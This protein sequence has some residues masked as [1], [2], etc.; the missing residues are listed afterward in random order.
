VELLV[1]IGIISLLIGLLLPAL[2]VAQDAARRTQCLSNLRQLATAAHLYAANHHDYY[3][4]AYYSASDGTTAFGYNWDFTTT[5][6]LTTGARSIIPG[7]LWSGQT[8]LRIQQCPSYD[9]RSM[10]A[11]DP[12]TGYNYNTSYIGHGD[13]EVAP[14][15]FVPPAKMSQVRK[16]SETALFG[17]GQ[18]ASGANK[19]MR[20]PLPNPL[21]PH[22]A[23]FAGTQGYRHRR[24]TNV[25]FC[26]GHAESRRERFT[27]GNSNVVPGTGFLSDDNSLYDLK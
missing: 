20:A 16:A 18:Y 12:Y 6:D 14:G 8:N 26:D 15:V 11:A 10:T 22:S 5:L 27:A 4:P 3:P 24:Q 9:G 23:S 1:V 19:Y 17:D 7:L 13:S 25:A 21:D 2:G